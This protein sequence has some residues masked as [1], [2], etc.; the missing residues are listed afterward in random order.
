MAHALC[1]RSAHLTKLVHLKEKFV[2]VFPHLF[3]Y[4]TTLSAAA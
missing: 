4:L 3:V 2:F 1:L